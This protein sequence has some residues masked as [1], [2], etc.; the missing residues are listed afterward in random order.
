MQN[1][2]TPNTDNT[3]TKKRFDV[4]NRKELVKSMKHYKGLYLMMIPGLI[5]LFILHY[6]PMYGILLA[7]KE[8]NFSKGIL[9][10]KWVGFKY[11]SQAFNDQYFIRA[12]K[13]TLVISGLKLFVGFP[14]P[15]I[16]ALLL[17][18]IRSLKFKKLAQTISYFPYFVSWVVL[19]GI[20]IKI[21]SPEGPINYLRSLMGNPPVLY[22][23]IP[24]WFLTIVVGTD[25]WRK[26]GW[27]AVIYLA[28]LS[29][30]DSQLYEAAYID[31]AGRWKQ[32][33]VSKIQGPNNSNASAIARI[34]GINTKVCS[35]ICVTA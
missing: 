30:I 3:I 2:S 11:F 25:I 1:M 23:S 10:S 17:N 31:G 21:F 4:N 27:G 14:I 24:K 7:F 35:F 22:F 8:F 12:V 15:V 34:L 29:N 18:E 6:L 33:I 5:L 13:N 20:F 9:G 28:A 19:T 32:T 16:F 26:L